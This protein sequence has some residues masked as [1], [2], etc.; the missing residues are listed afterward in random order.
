MKGGERFKKG[1]DFQRVDGKLLRRGKREGK[2]RVRFI[3][4]IN[5]AHIEG[6]EYGGKT[7]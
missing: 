3:C 4:S 6:R 2:N 5:M 7:P 1:V